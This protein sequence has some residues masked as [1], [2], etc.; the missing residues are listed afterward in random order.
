MFKCP[1]KHDRHKVWGST[2]TRNLLLQKN[3]LLAIL[4]PIREGH[5]E[6]S[7]N[8]KPE[9]GRSLTVEQEGEIVQ[10]LSFLSCCRKDPHTVTAIYIEEDED[11]QG[12][13][14]RLAV[15]GDTIS[16][17]EEWLQQN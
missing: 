2:A 14:V 1:A 17:I 9:Q 3:S 16:H 4:G 8:S 12:V 15:S 5:K 11:G 10:N 7:L 6:H 13:V